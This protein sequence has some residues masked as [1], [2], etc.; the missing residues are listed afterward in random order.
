MVT[1]PLEDTVL[2]IGAVTPR[3]LRRARPLAVTSRGATAARLIYPK[4]GVNVLP[5]GLYYNQGCPDNSR[6]NSDWA[7]E[8]EPAAIPCG[9]PGGKNADQEKGLT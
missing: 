5:P 2:K 9:G 7:M 3:V 8:R 4:N 6:T 1:C